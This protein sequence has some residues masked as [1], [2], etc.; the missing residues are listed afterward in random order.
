V[1]VDG[2]AK[3]YRGT[4]QADD[5]Q[6]PVGLGIRT[7]TIIVSPW[8]RGGN[9]CSQLFDHTSVLQFMEKRFGVMEPNISHWR[10]SVSGDLTSA[11]DFGDPAQSRVAPL[12][13]TADFRARV[14]QSAAGT[15]NAIPDRQQPTTQMPGQRPHRAL[16]YRFTVDSTIDGQGRFSL[17]LANQGRVGATFTVHDNSDA[18]E[19]WHYTIGAGDRFESAQWHDAGPLDRY[20]LTL[21][22]PNGYWRRYVGSLG[23]GAAALEVH[24]IDRPEHGEVELHL[25]NTTD[26]P[27]L[28]RI[29]LDEAYPTAATRVREITVPPHGQVTDRWS[30]TASDNWYDLTVRA[31]GA[32]T[33]L[34]RFAGKVE[35]GRA[36]R[37]DPGIGPMRTTI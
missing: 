11:F 6:H 37:T 30:L 13:S 17:L 14:A 16:P 28:F 1:P 34:R 5:T 3:D 7:P 25:V 12:P 8:T 10:R 9:V 23:E 21:R 22:G 19:P 35:T 26:R 15:A 36:G 2:E 33:F 18:Q 31:D 4:G 27:W 29:A 20:D 32:D 24:C